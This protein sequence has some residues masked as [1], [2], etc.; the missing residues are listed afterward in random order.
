[1]RRHLLENNAGG[2]VDHEQAAVSTADQR[3]AVARGETAAGWPT[4]R[5]RDRAEAALVCSRE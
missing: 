5:G 1:M 3:V 4:R 2:D